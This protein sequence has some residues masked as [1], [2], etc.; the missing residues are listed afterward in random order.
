MTTPNT[1]HLMVPGTWL[2]D[3]P[4]ELTLDAVGRVNLVIAATNS[5][6]NQILL[7]V[8]TAGSEP[9]PGHPRS[10]M[11]ADTARQA[12]EDLVLIRD[13]VSC[14]IHAV[15]AA[16]IAGGVDRSAVVQWAHYDADDQALIEG[17]GVVLAEHSDTD[18]GR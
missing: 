1:D 6:R 7:G 5:V 15:A 10:D 18:A 14:T 2:V 3:V 11:T 9:A 16:A 12:L 17:I 8:D 13:M 4:R